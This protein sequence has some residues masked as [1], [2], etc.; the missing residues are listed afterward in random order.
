M[1]TDHERAVETLWKDLRDLRADLKA[2]AVTLRE[3]AK[4]RV[5]DAR[6]AVSECAEHGAERIR[7]AADTAVDAGKRAMREVGRN[8]SERPVTSLLAALGIGMLVGAILRG[9]PRR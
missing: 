2:V 5:G 6:E 8:I 4:E 9:R 3:S 1:A 7:D